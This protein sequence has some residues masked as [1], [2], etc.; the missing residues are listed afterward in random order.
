MTL[1]RCIKQL[2]LVVAIISAVLAVTVLALQAQQKPAAPQ[3]GHTTP[4]GSGGHAHHGTPSG[5]KFTLPSG[6]AAKGREVFVKFACFSCH[7][8]EGETFPGS[9][10]S[11]K[12][13]PEL[14]AMGPLHDAEFF[15]EAI[16][17]PSAVVEKGKGY[18]TADGSSKMPA[19][20]SA[21]T[22]QD[23]IDLVTYLRGLKPPAKASVGKGGGSDPHSGHGKH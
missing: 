6:D 3:S 14:A 9:G 18:E 5:W 15:A 16:V 22:V 13:G 19:Y 23:L 8:V 7:E 1:H 2:L 21:L 4:Q 17:N 12:I 11:G 10:V 20:N